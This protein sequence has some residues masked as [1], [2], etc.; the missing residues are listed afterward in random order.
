MKTILFATSCLATVAACTPAQKETTAKKPNIIIIYVD[1]LGFGD[2]GV[3]GAK[4]VKT[5][6]VDR[7]ALNG[8]NFTDAHCSAATYTPSRF[9]LLTGT[10]AFRNNAAILPG[11]APLLIDPN[12]GTLPSMLK[13]AGYTTGVI[14]KWHLGLGRGIVNWNEEIKPDPREIGFYYSFIIPATLDRVPTVFVENQKIVNLDSKDTVAINYDHKIGNLPTGLEHPE[15][16]KFKADVQHSGTIIDSISQIGYMSGGQSSRWKDEDIADMLINKVKIFIHKNSKTPFFLY[17]AITDIH[18][19]RAPNSRFVGKSTMGARGDAI[20]EM[21]WSTGEVLKTLD[22]IGLT[23]NTLIIFS[24][25]NGPILDDGYT[26]QAAELLGDH[27]PGGSYRGAKYSILEAGTRMPTIVSWPGTVDP[28]ISTAMLTQVDL[29]ASL[30][31]LVGQE[32]KPGN[33]YEN[34]ATS[35]IAGNTLLTGKNIPVAGECEVKN[36]QAM[37]IMAEFG[38]GGSFSEFYLMDFIDD[39][40]MLG[41]DGPAHF[42]IAEGRVKLVPLPVYHGKPGKG[43]SIQMTVKYGPVTLLSVVEGK[44]GI[45]L[46]VAEGETIT[47][48]VLE[49]GNTN[50]RYRFS[51]GARE[52]MNQW[53]KQGPAHHCAIGVGHIA[54]KIE[55]LGR[56][57][58][59][60]VV[61]IC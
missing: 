39:I 53:S 1:D 46:L 19:P 2:I 34:I 37:K 22:E 54:D 31:K 25:D 43:L 9:S 12:K 32:V 33:D 56:I 60:E 50:S 13:Q 10:Y 58:G 29:Y 51:I 6:N 28:G 17:F 20:A 16:L 30:A 52:F 23:D 41:H 11:G 59:I 3:N 40:V 15:M 26:D 8:V 36:A 61:K 38:A 7:L 35:V 57:L 49:I 45:F 44:N 47:G 5:P 14:G 18:V 55:K 27:K 42:A 21:D 24:S 48:P 4:G